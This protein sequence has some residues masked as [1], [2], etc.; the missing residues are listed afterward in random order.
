[1]EQVQSTKA[2]RTHLP[3]KAKVGFAI[4][5]VYVLLGVFGPILL[6][7]DPDKAN[8]LQR[9]KPPSSTHWLGTDQL[10]RDFLI[11]LL[12]AIRI[13]IPV[14]FAAA[15]FPMVIGT[16]LG[17]IAGYYGKFTDLIVSRAADMVQAFPVYVF[18]LVLVFALGSGATSFIIA[19][20]AIAWVGYARLTRG[21]VLRLKGQEF[22]A[23]A[24]VTGLPE[25]KTL[26]THVMPNALPQ[27]LIYFMSDVVLM[28]LVLSSLSFLGVGIQ[29]PTA[30][31]GRMISEGQPFLHSHWRLAVAPGLML[32]VFGIALSLIADGLDEWFRA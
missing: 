4:L 32:M 16:A 3:G 5:A 20:T 14:A 9:L 19:A 31:W 18:L 28:V 27:T 2:A 1:M 13:D 11:R 23:A 17:A 15:F 30:E 29:P 6:P 12:Y 22:V 21:E 8:V 24:R 10:G 26:V 25:W 7:F